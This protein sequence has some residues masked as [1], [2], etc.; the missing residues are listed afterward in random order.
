MAE[1]CTN[2]AVRLALGT[3]QF[4]LAYGVRGESSPVPEKEIS[5]ILE[6]AAASGVRTLD[7]A[8]V[9]GNIEP[10]IRRLIG[11]L[12]F[13]VI[14][15][16][17]AIPVDLPPRDAGQFALQSALCS[18]ERIG[19]S[20][21][22]L[23]FHRSTDF[24][25]IRGEALEKALR[26]WARDEGLLLGVSC[27]GPEDLRAVR[28]ERAVSIAQVPGNALDQRLPLS[29][30]DG[31]PDVEIH[32]RSAF[33]QGLLMMPSQLAAR[34]V[35]AATQALEKWH[36]R[37]Q[38]L[39]LSPLHAALGIVKSFTPLNTVVVGVD[40]LGHWHQ[41]FEAWSQVAPFSAPDLACHDKST[42][43]PREWPK[44]QP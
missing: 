27:Y 36:A 22:G 28:A 31:F 19:P 17:P 37:C 14:S 34:R 10:R 32:V 30:P 26:G 39:G 9:Y 40:N 24:L 15:K 23:L 18:R 5:Q 8:P 4:G 7:T 21:H 42:I 35:P 16:I 43:D 3:V 1:S 38:S 25:G 29:S 11:D 13:R 6:A 12:P 44:L 41:I 33:L 20:L 2:G